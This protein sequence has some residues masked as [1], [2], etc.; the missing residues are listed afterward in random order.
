MRTED[1]DDTLYPGGTGI[2]PALKRNIDE[3]LMAR[4]GL[5]ADTA[6]ALRVELFRTHGS[7]LAGLIVR[8]IKIP[9][10]TPTLPLPL[11]GKSFLS[12]LTYVARLFPFSPPPLMWIFFLQALGYDV[13]PDEYHRSAR[14]THPFNFLFSRLNG[15]KP[16]LI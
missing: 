9:R 1:L 10:R 4:Y 3:F 12:F 13:H 15:S 8:F 6:A 11:L 5:A 7:T 2:G 14:N 16:S